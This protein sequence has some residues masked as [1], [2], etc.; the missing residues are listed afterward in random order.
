MST[1]D[2]INSMSSCA[3]C[4]KGEEGSDNL[5]TCN[6]CKM[7]KYCN[8][9]CQKAHRPHHKGEC[10]KRAA[11]LHNEA[12]F[13]QPPPN[14]ECP[15]CM[16]PLPSR[17]EGKRYQTCCGQTLCCGCM[18]QTIAAVRHETC[19]FCKTPIYDTEE[20]NNARIMK[21]V[22]ANDANA[23][24]N[25]GT[26]YDLGQRGFPRDSVMAHKLWHQ[27]GKLGRR[28]AYYSIGIDYMHG[29]GCVSRDMKKA[30][31]YWELA[32]I[33]GHAGARH[34][35]GQYEYEI[36]RNKDKALKHYMIAAA[37]GSTNSLTAIRGYYLHGLATKDEYGK[38]IRAYH[39]FKDEV[40]SEHREKAAALGN[41][42]YYEDV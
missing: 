18:I 15:I 8:A 36:L 1:T 31:H 14:E 40:K 27:A 2:N 32:A 21:R 16:I 24:Y 4:G 17:A 9:A 37:T 33:L 5:K 7:V 19:P 22:K 3:N 11:E 10:K 29:S 42:Q 41:F 13:K 26:Y 20:D 23:L 38:A 12:L 25:L 39:A 30:K 6:G 35:L 28:D 34:N